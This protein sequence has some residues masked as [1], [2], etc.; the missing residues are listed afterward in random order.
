MSFEQYPGS[1]SIDRS[2][3]LAYHCITKHTNALSKLRRLLDRL[4]SLPIGEYFV[5]C[6]VL[7]LDIPYD[8]AIYR[9]V[10]RILGSQ[11]ERLQLGHSGTQGHKYITLHNKH[12]GKWYRLTI[13]MDPT[14]DDSKCTLIAGPIE[15]KQTMIVECTR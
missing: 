6:D 14:T 1:P 10:R 13:V 2:K 15:Q 3:A 8:W 9:Q 5:S 12:R 7:Y 4:P 11:W